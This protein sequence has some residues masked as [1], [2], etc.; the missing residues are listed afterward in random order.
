MN[1]PRPSRAHGSLSPAAAGE[2]E[3]RS[4]GEFRS[5]PS[6]VRVQKS[7]FTLAELLVVIVIIGVLA[8]IGIPALR[9]LGESTSID[10]ATRQILDDL[11]FA[12]Q[13]AINDRTTVYML[14]V[15]P[16]VGTQVTNLVPLRLRG[17]TLFARRTVGEQ[18]GRQ[19]P[20]QLIPWRA[21]PDATHVPLT[22]FLGIPAGVT[23]NNNV[24]AYEQPFAWTNNFELEITNVTK[25]LAMNY[26]AFN[27]QGQLVQFDGR[28]ATVSQENAYVPLVRGSIFN[29]V[30]SQGRYL[31]ELPDAVEVPVGNRRYIKINWLTG[32]A[33]VL[34]DYFLSDTNAQPTLGPE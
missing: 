24:R 26:L 5:P 6:A 33:E 3:S 7:A 14:F 18:P 34:G 25:R 11:A 28:G 10:S 8:A 21:L 1:R 31:L 9:G 30:D 19:S 13:R 23:I 16:N 17:Y 29:P 4:A 2:G 27:P 20:R 22:K 15:P 12:R 32:R